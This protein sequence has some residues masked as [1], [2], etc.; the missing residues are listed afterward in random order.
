MIPCS[1]GA[2]WMVKRLTFFLLIVV[3][4][5]IAGC[6]P[7][8]GNT[9]LTEPT[10]VTGEPSSMTPTTPDATNLEALPQ[11]TQAKEDLA[12]RLN[13]P[14]D[15]IEIVEVQMRTWSDASMGCP[16]PGMEYPQVP[17]DGL[18]VRL[19]A[20]GQEYNY[21]SGGTR[22]PFLCEQALPEKSTPVFGEDI[23]TPPSSEDD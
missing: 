22:E 17:E 9:P 19:R 2:K 6:Q 18:L 10:A 12:G 15:Q 8:T 7:A 23:L 4:A 21:H 3:L 11:V 13:V 16:Q 1:Q 14:S 5:G 20:A